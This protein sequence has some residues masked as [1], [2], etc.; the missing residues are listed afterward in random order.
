MNQ[1]IIN[2]IQEKEVEVDKFIHNRYLVGPSAIGS[3]LASLFIL[4]ILDV[5]KEQLFIG[6]GLVVFLQPYLWPFCFPLLN[7]GRRLRLNDDILTIL[8]DSGSV[9]IDLKRDVDY[10]LTNYK[11]GVINIYKKS[12]F[13]KHTIVPLSIKD[14]DFTAGI[15]SFFEK[16][17]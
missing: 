2:D 12:D 5:P 16:S 3:I 13:T 17:Q 14:T 9:T 10:K 1:E 11:F 4:L 8:D 6:V 15:L 7:G